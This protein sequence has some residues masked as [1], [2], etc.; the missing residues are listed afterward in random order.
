MHTPVRVYVYVCTDTYTSPTTHAR[1]IKYKP[2]DS[3]GDVL[4]CRPCHVDLLKHERPRRSEFNDF[5]SPVPEMQ[6]LTLVEMCLLAPVIC[7]VNVVKLVCFGSPNT[8]Q[9]AI[10]GNSIAFMQDINSMIKQLPHKDSLANTLKVVFIGDTTCAPHYQKIKKIL[11]V[12]RARVQAAL[13]FLVKKHSGFLSHGITIN[14]PQIDALPVDD[15]PQELLDS[16]V[17]SPN[18]DAANTENSSYVP[19]PVPSADDH[20]NLDIPMATS[21]VVDADASSVPTGDLLSAASANLREFDPSFDV[22]CTSGNVPYSHYNNPD[23]W[24]LSFPTL[25]PY[26]KGGNDG[27]ISMES[28]SKHLLLHRDSRFRLHYSFMF[29]LYSIITVQKVCRQTKYTIAYRSKGCSVLPTLS[30]QEL[31]DTI[32]SMSDKSSYQSLPPRLQTLMA[33]LRAVGSSVEGSDFLKGS[34]RHNINAL[35]LSIGQP[36]FFVTI[37]PADLHHP[38]LLHFADQS[39]NLDDPFSINWLNKQD[40]CKL[41]AKD[42][43]ATAQ[44]FHKMIDIWLSTIL[45]VAPSVKRNTIGVLGR[46]AGYFGTVETQ[47]RGSLHLHILIWIAGCP[48]PTEMQAMLSPTT[49]HNQEFRTAL[50]SYLDS[51]IQEEVPQTTTP[52]VVL[53]DPNTVNNPAGQ[54]VLNTM[55]PIPIVLPTE[56]PNSHV[57]SFLPPDPR[58]PNFDEAYLTDISRLVNAC[59]IHHHT[60]TCRKYGSASCRFDFPRP[61]IEVSHITDGGVIWLRRRKGNGWVNNYN[62]VFTAAMRCDNDIKF[63]TNGA[64][65]KALSFYIT[66]YITK[67]AMTTHNAFPLILAAMDSIESGQFPCSRDSSLTISQQLSR[68]LIVKCLNKLSTQSERSGPE[69]ASILLGLPLHYTQH[70]F[71]KLFLFSFM[72]WFREHQTVPMDDPTCTDSDDVNPKS[73]SHPLPVPDVLSDDDSDGVHLPTLPTT[74]FNLYLTTMVISQCVTSASI[75]YTAMSRSKMYPSMISCL[76]TTK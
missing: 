36:T 60:A 47:G 70:T 69:V 29:V 28:W 56:D 20:D 15:V 24:T 25:F 33:E 65:S 62:D 10:K 23:F 31:R 32:K 19:E 38:V 18:S 50:L 76:V 66:D 12:R 2:Y 16:I 52:A 64:D 57:C 7:K 8:A 55:P 53:A 11:T 34:L 37:N 42:P 3:V 41:V 13:E 22:Q 61:A 59:Q 35:M 46:V 51:T 74:L 72:P 43:V 14:Q 6:D 75:I 54:P 73:H 71:C 48:S 1:N 26:G 67:N 58:K 68:N 40:R 45:G 4:V 39:I 27:S 5:G 63:L 17:Y 9:R 21:G 49:L 44:F 30:P